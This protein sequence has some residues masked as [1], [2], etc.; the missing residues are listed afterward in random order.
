MS[1]PSTF[2]TSYLGVT[3]VVFHIAT[4]VIVMAMITIFILMI[5]VVIAR[6]ICERPRKEGE[7]LDEARERQAHNAAMDGAFAAAMGL[8][9]LIA[10]VI[11][12]CVLLPFPSTPC[13]K[14]DPGEPPAWDMEIAELTSGRLRHLRLRAMYM[15]FMLN[16]GQ[17]R[18]QAR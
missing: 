8:L 18:L 12:I 11:T 17:N 9:F 16:M 13:L 7:S 4:Q 10:V 5:Y 14:I 15:D 1:D 2:M 3:S 6:L